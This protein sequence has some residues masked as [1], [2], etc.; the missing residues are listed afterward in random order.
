MTTPVLKL[1]AT[2]N[3]LS[4]VRIL[5]HPQ[6]TF[7]RKIYAYNFSTFSN[8]KLQIFIA[9]SWQLRLSAKLPKKF[10]RW[11]NLYV[12]F[13]SVNILSWLKIIS[14]VTFIIRSSLQFFVTCVLLLLL[15]FLCR[16]KMLVMLRNIFE[17]SITIAICTQKPSWKKVGIVTRFISQFFLLSDIFDLYR[18]DFKSR[19][20]PEFLI[21]KNDQNS[22]AKLN[23]N[24]QLKYNF[25]AD[26][27]VYL[28]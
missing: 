21:I 5:F 18:Y 25:I 1:T 26:V 20:T 27:I 13:M 19:S 11:R 7:T 22:V 3:N 17:Y 4:H 15:L 6:I 12:V 10:N 14:L 23:N 9:C 28:R 8:Q 24:Q 2:R 16:V